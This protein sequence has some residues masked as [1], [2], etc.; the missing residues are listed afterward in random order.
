MS[1]GRGRPEP[2]P[3]DRPG[4]SPVHGGTGGRRDRAV[5]R[6]RDQRVD[7]LQRVESAD[8][9]GVAQ[10][11]RA[12]GGLRRAHAGE[13]G[14]QFLGDVGAE[15][16][17]RPGEPVGVRTEPLQSGDEPAAPGGGAERAEFTRGLL[18]GR[19]FVV[20][21]LGDQFDRLVRVAAGDRPHL[22]AERVVGVLAERRPD[23]YGGGV[24]CQGAQR[25]AGHL[26]L[27]VGVTLG[28]PVRD[29]AG[30]AFGH[31]LRTVRLHHQDRQFTEAGG[32]RGQPGE[33]FT[34]RPVRVVHDEQQRAVAEPADDVVQAVAHTLRVGL[35][36]ARLGQPEGRGDDLEPVAEQGPGLVRRELVEGGLQQ[37]AYDVE[38]YGG[39]GLAS[40]AGPDGA[41]VGGHRLDLVE[42]RG[43]ADPSLSAEDQEPS[44]GLRAAQG[45]QRL[46]S[47][48][49][50]RFTFVQRPGRL[51]AHPSHRGCVLGLRA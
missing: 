17:R 3:G 22:T 51:H 44:G 23:Q 47:D 35:R 1:G 21:D 32:E 12:V 10:P 46:G 33:G 9:T 27:A 39:D 40:P 19:Q 4:G 41:A 28:R 37:L 45:V 8:D 49:E 50:F 29:V 20:L 2:G 5:D 15:H 18:H 24:R 48:G 34:V 25:D 13:G 7:E 42:Q 14:G 6:G 43:L 11:G 31:L 36:S 16:G 26:L 38:R 30:V